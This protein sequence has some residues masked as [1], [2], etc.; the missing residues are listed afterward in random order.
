MRIDILT[1]FPEIAMAPLGESM[2]K[3]AREAGLVEVQAHDLRGWATGKH[4]KTDDYLC[5]GGQGMLLKPEPIF[6]AIEELRKEET[7]VILLTPQGQ[8]FKQAKALELSGEKHLIFLCGHYE[9]VD[10]RVIEELV[11]LELS[12]GDYVLTNGAIA[13]AVVTD[14]V[15]RLLPGALGDARSAVD[16]SFSDPNLLEAPAYTKPIEFR[17][18]K[19]PDILL[20]GHH[21]KI[22]EWKAEMSIK[23]T[24][25]NR[26]DL[27]E[28]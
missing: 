2:M 12:I 21:A 17:G 7:Q 6:A 16:E 5:G 20:S 18:L 23:R 11:D 13:A 28:E 22:E 15:V 25:E 19:V 24:K 26:P 10:H 27:L 3:R 14:A 4:R 9:G 8:V 1:L